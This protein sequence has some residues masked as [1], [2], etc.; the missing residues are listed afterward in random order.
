MQITTDLRGYMSVDKHNTAHINQMVSFSTTVKKFTATM[1]AVS[2]RDSILQALVEGVFGQPQGYCI[3]LRADDSVIAGGSISAGGTCLIG[4]DFYGFVWS[5]GAVDF[6]IY[7]QDGAEGLESNFLSCLPNRVPFTRAAQFVGYPCSNFCSMGDKVTETFPSETAFAACPDFDFGYLDPLNRL[8][9]A[10]GIETGTWNMDIVPKSSRA[11]MK[12]LLIPERRLPVAKVLDARE[13]VYVADANTGAELKEALATGDSLSKFNSKV[14]RYALPA[15]GALENSG[16]LTFA[17]IPSKKTISALSGSI[18]HVYF[19]LDLPGFNEAV[20]A[21]ADF[22]GDEISRYS[23]FTAIVSPISRLTAVIE[24]YYGKFVEFKAQ[25]TELAKSTISDA[26]ANGNLVVLR[27][28]Q[29]GLKFVDHC[30]KSVDLSGIEF[31]D[32]YDHLDLDILIKDLSNKVQSETDL[33]KVLSQI[34]TDSHWVCGIACM[35]TSSYLKE[36]KAAYAEYGITFPQESYDTNPALTVVVDIPLLKSYL[37]NQAKKQSDGVVKLLSGIM[38]SLRDEGPNPPASWLYKAGNVVHGS[39]TER[40]TIYAWC[41]TRDSWRT[42]VMH[43]FSSPNSLRDL[44]DF[45]YGNGP[46]IDK[47][48]R[49]LVDGNRTELMIKPY[50]KFKNVKVKA[51]DHNRSSIALDITFPIASAMYFT[52]SPL[53][54]FGP[55]AAKI[56]RTCFEAF[57]CSKV[58]ARFAGT[59]SSGY[60]GDIPET[61]KTHRVCYWHWRS[62]HVG[63]R[64]CSY[65]QHGETFWRQV[66]P[67]VVHLECEVDKPTVLSLDEFTPDVANMATSPTAISNVIER[68]V[69]SLVGKAQHDAIMWLINQLDALGMLG[70]V[71]AVGKVRPAGSEVEEV[72]TLA[73]LANLSNAALTDVNDI[74]K[75]LNTIIDT[76]DVSGQ[77]PDSVGATT[78]I[79]TGEGYSS[80]RD[81]LIRLRDSL[82][83]FAS[84]SR[85][86]IWFFGGA[87]PVPI[88]TDWN[89]AGWYLKV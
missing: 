65:P 59:D 88:E 25:L 28:T 29:Q 37:K 2:G 45:I 13:G 19:D 53:E 31:F 8:R 33:P 66:P 86:K 49:R 48:N 38:Q 89:L 68:G 73:A 23:P 83:E 42:N 12:S 80:E 10:T 26:A 44:H 1:N 54:T 39:V 55:M 5:A 32:G 35:Y 30:N 60:N 58:N 47:E 27:F 34:V 82:V 87:Q 74:V 81:N 11:V 70:E 75:C 36:I 15:S 69:V 52:K 85:E 71:T 51:L 67:I 40:K 22:G 4:K 76:K 72:H 84:A 24:E 77:T 61:Y 63:G 50:T 20:L 79:L 64:E 62:V 46:C 57:G 7:V 14:V 9:L 6:T 78:S 16:V 41:T 17:V 21:L 18:S 3:R 43:P 56:I